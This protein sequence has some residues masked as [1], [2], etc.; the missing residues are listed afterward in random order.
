MKLVSAAATVVL[1]GLA[2]APASAQ[3][4]AALFARDCA[5][6]HT[7]DEAPS[8]D[9]LSRMA[10]NAI[11]TALTTGSMRMMGTLLTIPERRAMAEFLTGKPV[12]T[13]PV[14]A[15]IGRCAESGPM[16]DPAAGPRWNGWGVD[17]RNTRYQPAAQGG[18]TAADL[19]RLTLKWAFGFR[20]V[21]A[22]RAQP[23]VA[24][25]RVFVGSEAGIVY[26]LDAKTGCTHWTFNT[27]TGLRTAI[28]VGP[29][30][31]AS[32][33]GQAI[34]FADGAANAYAVD[35]TTGR[36]IWT[37]QVDDHA[38][39]RATGSPMLYNGILYV[40]VAGLG[41]EAQGG[42]A[43]YECCTFRG[44][45][46]ALDASTG[47][48]VWK[49]YVMP[50]PQ[51]RGRNQAGVPVWGP[52]GGG[53]WAA[54]TI[55]VK[56]DVLYVST[57]NGYAEPA[58]PT[59]NAVLAFDLKT[60]ALRWSHQTTPN[61]IW[62]MGCQQKNPDN[63]NCPETL[64]PDM[65]FSA[66]P[67]LATTSA[68]RDLLVIPQKS[69][70]AYG[71][72][73]DNGGTR[74]WQYRAGEG[75]GLGGVWGAAVA[76]DVAYIAANDFFSPDPGGMN[77]VRLET[78]ERLW[79]TPPPPKL[80][81][82]GRTCVAAQGAAVTAIPGAVLSGSHDGGLRA[83]SAEDGVII[84]TFD[85][86]RSFETI[87]GVEANGGSMDG[88]GPVVAGGLLLVNSGY[89]GVVGRPGNVLLVFGVD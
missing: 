67:V 87:N 82:D 39:A 51:S 7:T 63:P 17:L 62:A 45:V 75:S 23:A 55:D 66:S 89:G 24:G 59:T 10:P 50:E 20:D 65:D 29:Y 57:G 12:V 22:A 14:D 78:G 69:G 6:C 53:I 80:C 15:S 72:D 16:P 30:T 41:E 74:V 76:G 48:V 64:G 11:V 9:V 44:S 77:A 70:L 33:A 71:L 85:T 19:P 25:G 35:A 18:V 8:R 83:Y 43:Q 81:G 52:A 13:D 4:G 56:R 2:A 34:Y 31:G 61:D 28:S 54:P 21:V 32:G 49:S 88:P 38:S 79:Y 37:R 86:N 60:G 5:T 42:R 1:V 47:A 26:A 68:G 27:K 3:D 84:W 40:P 46:S 58:Q 36:Q 73:P